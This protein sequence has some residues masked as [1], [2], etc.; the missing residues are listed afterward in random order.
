VVCVTGIATIVCYGIDGI[1]AVKRVLNRVKEE[2]KVNI[3]YVSMGHFRFTLSTEFVEEGCEKINDAMEKAVA[4]IIEEKG[5]EG[6]IV[7]NAVWDTKEKDIKS[8]VQ[9]MD[10]GVELED[11]FVEDCEESDEN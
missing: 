8:L 2:C 11:E 10:Q 3:H 1:D 9:R 5:G 4:Y 7:D 6:K